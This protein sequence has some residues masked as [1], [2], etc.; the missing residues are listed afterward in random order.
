MAT[1]L[2]NCVALAISHQQ[3]VVWDTTIW[4]NLENFEKSFLFH[5]P[6]LV[7]GLKIGY[8]PVI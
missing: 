2:V 8:S 1:V 5:D 7:I 4:D 3:T 6:R